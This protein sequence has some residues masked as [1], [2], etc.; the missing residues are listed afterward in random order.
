MDARVEQ[1][2]RVSRQWINCLG[3]VGFAQ[4]APGAGPGKIV[5][6]CRAALGGRYN[7]LQV[8]HDCLRP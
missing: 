8:Q 5:R 6:S 7:V 1:R 4:V 3:S 2:N